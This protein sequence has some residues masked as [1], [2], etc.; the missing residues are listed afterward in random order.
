MTAS[1]LKASLKGVSEVAELYDMPIAHDIIFQPIIPWPAP[2]KL[3][4]LAIAESL[5]LRTVELLP[6][7]SNN[8][9]LQ[10]ESI[11]NR[12]SHEVTNLD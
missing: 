9:S 6:I 3:L 4:A 5:E 12:L 7:V 8:C 10:V 11:D 1:I 2:D